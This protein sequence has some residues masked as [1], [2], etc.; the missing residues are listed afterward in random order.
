MVK[1][2]RTVIIRCILSLH[3]LDQLTH[4]RLFFQTSYDLDGQSVVAV[5]QIYLLQRFVLGNVSDLVQLF[6]VFYDYC[7]PLFALEFLFVNF[8]Q[9]ANFIGFVAFSI[10]QDDSHIKILL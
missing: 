10:D 5:A 6:V 3:N 7:R 9:I 4:G 8:N 2:H 1:D